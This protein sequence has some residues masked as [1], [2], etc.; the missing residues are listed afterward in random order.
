MKDPLSHT[1]VRN[2]FE[3]L[4]RSECYKMTMHLVKKFKSN[5]LLD[6]NPPIR[7][8]KNFDVDDCLKMSPV[9]QVITG[10]N[11]YSKII[12]V[13]LFHLLLIK[14]THWIPTQ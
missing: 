4:I 2:C 8:S 5:Q 3:I 1:V 9:Y 13:Q 14:C 7:Y 12:Q 11:C 10:K 6:F